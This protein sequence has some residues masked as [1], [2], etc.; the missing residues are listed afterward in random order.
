MNK[1]IYL[2]GPDFAGKTHL[3]NQI[4]CD[5]DVFVHNGVFPSSLEA[6]KEYYFQIRTF[7]E[8]VDNEDKDFNFIMDRG[9]IAEYIY[10]TIM[11]NEEVNM[12]DILW[13]LN[14]MRVLDSVLVLCLPPLEVSL[15]GWESRVDEEYVKKLETYTKIWDAYKEVLSWDLPIPIIHYDFTQTSEYKK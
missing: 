14:C 1:L 13:L 15:E 4:K 2:E 9:P 12:D 6:L 3:I 5:E 10:G 11:R 7:G 8:A